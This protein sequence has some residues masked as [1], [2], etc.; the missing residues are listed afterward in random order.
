VTTDGWFPIAFAIAIAAGTVADRPL[1]PDQRLIGGYRVLAGDF[2]LHSGMWSG[3]TLTPW[4]LVLEAERQ[5]LDVIALTA[6][7]ETWDARVARAFARLAGGPVV[8]VGEEVTSPTQDLIAV[9]IET[10]ISPWLPLVQQVAEVHRQGGVAIAPHPGVE[11]RR[12]YLE[13]G[14][15]AL[16]DGVEVCHPSIYSQTGRA[17]QYSA[18]L[19]ETGA[20]PIGSSDFHWSSRAGRC[21]TFVFVR[22]VSERGVLEALRA[23]RTV[24]YVGN[25]AF[26]TPELVRLADSAGLAARA[27][28]SLE[29]RGTVIDWIARAAAGAGMLGVALWFRAHATRRGAARP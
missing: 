27:Q 15:S 3:G 23:H 5:G 17:A 24:V 28:S 25:Q 16:I 21:R 14:A 12:A 11:Y 1:L 13:S 2:H 29:S 18:F 20:A 26:G 8:L 22:E 4:G 19:A 10:T 7:N 6:H 9:G